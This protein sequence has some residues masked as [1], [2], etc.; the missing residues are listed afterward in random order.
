MGEAMP[1]LL[2]HA[3]GIPRYAKSNERSK[4]RMNTEV[5][6]HPYVLGALARFLL[7][8][9]PSYAPAV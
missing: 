3:A 2:H 6:Q 4:I 9:Y 8:G 5:L 7:D 1:R